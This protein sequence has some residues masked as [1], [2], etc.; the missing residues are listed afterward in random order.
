[1]GVGWVRERR[2]TCAMAVRGVGDAERYGSMSLYVVG[3]VGFLS[4]ISV[5][6]IL[7]IMTT[8]IAIVCFNFGGPTQDNGDGDDNA[9]PRQW[10]QPS[11]PSLRESQYTVDKKAMD[12]PGTQVEKVPVA[13]TAADENQIPICSRLFVC[14]FHRLC[15]P[16]DE[17]Q[18]PSSKQ[19]CVVPLLCSYV[20][21]LISSRDFLL[22]FLSRFF[23]QVCNHTSPVH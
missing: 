18:E 2:T 14:R 8:V 13:E 19:C 10:D 22:V 15:R 21:P 20:K 11:R 5:I 3:P 12:E 7:S 17:Q 4:I 16:R 23:F 9:E 1:M 6:W